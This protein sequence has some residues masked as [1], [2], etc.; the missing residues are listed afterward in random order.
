MVKLKP[1][2]CAV[3][4]TAALVAATAIVTS[5]IILRY[6]TKDIVSNETK[7]REGPKA[8]E[9]IIAND[10]ASESSKF[11]SAISNLF[12]NPSDV[13]AESAYRQSQ[14]FFVKIFLDGSYMPQPTANKL[15]SNYISQADLCLRGF[16]QVPNN[17][18]VSDYT[19]RVNWEIGLAKELIVHGW[20]YQRLCSI[21]EKKYDF[22]P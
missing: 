7:H 1:I 15:F 5:A 12:A 17:A 19:K 21:L 6:K 3:A 20:D 14:A 9:N 10:I 22:W 2:F 13:N 4:A 16:E 18:H 8:L 11:N